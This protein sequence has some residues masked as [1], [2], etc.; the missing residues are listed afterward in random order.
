[1]SKPLFDMSDADV[2]EAPLRTAEH[3]VYSYNDYLAELDRRSNRRMTL[4]I[5]VA[6][7]VY[8]V[9]TAVLIAVTALKP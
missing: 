6:T 5:A 2:R 4:A 3:V 7:T 9:L 1:M 8:A